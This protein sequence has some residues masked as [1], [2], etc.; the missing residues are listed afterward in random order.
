MLRTNILA[1]YVL[2]KVSY[3]NNDVF[4]CCI[5]LIPY[6]DDVVSNVLSNVTNTLIWTNFA[7]FTMS[8]VNTDY[9]TTNLALSLGL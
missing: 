7:L 4:I 8:Y 3:T 1:F 6:V 2:P 5:S 9:S